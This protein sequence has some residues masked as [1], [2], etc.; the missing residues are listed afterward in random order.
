M[1]KSVHDLTQGPIG[2]QL[3]AFTL[4]ILMGNVL[5]SLNAS[6]N[7]VW[8]GHYIGAAAL[9]ATSN[10][11]AVL[12][13]LIGSAFG[14]S[15]AATILIGQQIGRKQ[16]TEAKRV[17]GASGFFFLIVSM[18]LSVIGLLTNDWLLGL[19]GLPADA[20]PLAS[21]Y[22]NVIYLALPFIFMYTFVIATLRGAGDSKTPFLFL[23]VSVGLDIALNPV[24]MFGLGP[25]HG[26]GIAGSAL[27]TLIA[28]AI[29]LAALIA[30]LYQRNDPL[31][32]RGVELKWFSFDAEIVKL[33]LQKGM[34]MGLQMILVS[35]SLVVMITLVNPYGSAVTAAYGG[36]WQL[37]NYVQ[38][39]AM[40]L[41]ASVSA[42]A[43][44]NVGAQRW[45]RITVLTWVGV[46]YSV[47]ATGIASVGL[48][49]CDRF[50]LGLFIIDP[51]II[52]TARHINHISIVAFVL[53][54]MSMVF[55]SVVR[56]T[57]AVMA[58]VLILVITLWGVRFP[59]AYIMQSRM[60]V[61]A[62]WWSFPLSS[63]LSLLFAASYYFFG[64][65]K[66]MHMDLHRP[67]APNDTLILKST[68]NQPVTS[69]LTVDPKASTNTNGL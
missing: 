22:L 28:N 6:I 2:K 5:Q 64:S 62:V 66:K 9:T 33:L 65:W 59:F 36:A 46:G 10:V 20:L 60:G 18:S 54:G 69:D 42:M 44:Q 57:G 40:A 63:S 52:E 19:M 47:L 68:T 51:A 61:D 31:C 15:M 37:W 55:S 14:V 45:D 24:L 35:L 34:P 8:V 1:S 32:L 38:M 39:P 58:P 21:A 7:T 43:A 16:L 25:W 13:L 11:N 29:T 4:P 53:F 3:L 41:G 12:F 50:L 27:A 56:A 23:L 48:V 49:L 30:R 17:I 67:A 26:F